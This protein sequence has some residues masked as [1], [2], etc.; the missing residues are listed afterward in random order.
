MC[1]SDPCLKYQL[2]TGRPMYKKI[3][4][5]VLDFTRYDKFI[6]LNLLI[7][8]IL[9]LKIIQATLVMNIDSTTVDM[10][11]MIP[12]TTLTTLRELH[13]VPSH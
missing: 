11:D 7:P 5:K 1:P 2:E 8:R 3:I 6:Y 12:I 4:K 10:A 9:L 13:M